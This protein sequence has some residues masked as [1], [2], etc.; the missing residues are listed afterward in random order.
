MSLAERLR[1]AYLRWSRLGAASLL[2][3][4]FAVTSL[5]GFLWLHERGMLLWFVLGC[6]G[7]ASGIW[8]GRLALAWQHR[9]RARA[10]GEAIDEDDSQDAGEGLRA[11]LAHPPI[12]PEWSARETEIYEAARAAIT[13]RLTGPVEWESLPEQAVAVVEDVAGR[14][15]GGKR[16][17]LDFTLPEALLLIDRVA[18][19]YREFLRSHVPFSDQL[20]M[21]SVHWLWSRQDQARTA[22]KYGYLAYRGL[23]LAFNPPVGVLR[24]LERAATA[25]LQDRLSDQVVRDAQAILLEEVAQAAVDLYSGRLKF[26]DA[27]LIEI[28]LGSELRDRRSLARPDDPVRIIVVGQISA[29]K[30]T[31]IN[32]LAGDE[33]A[34]TDL[35]PT[36]D[37]LTAHEMEIDD[38][39]CRLIDT[40]GLDGSSRVHKALTAEILEADMV[41]WVLRANR[42]GRAV[43]I[44]LRDAVM[45]AFAEDPARRI[46]PIIPLATAVDMLLP[47]WPYTENR[48]P[49]AAQR[50]I[51]RM[52]TALRAD[53]AGPLGDRPPIPVCARP[54]SWNL[55]TLHNAIA[56]QLGDALMTQRNRRRLESPQGLR[57]G[58]NLGRAGRGVAAGVKVFGGRLW[59]AARNPGDKDAAPT[60][61]VGPRLPAKEPAK[62][63]TPE[64]GVFRKPRAPKD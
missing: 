45:A 29:G 5:L 40:M 23:R 49:E 59:Q 63:K 34:E 37:T 31:L 60:K 21:R 54:P 30:S 26:S 32:A 20:S 52:I 51:G 2:V 48:L 18:L 46:P 55:D 47:D 14:M 12:D 6:V 7:L 61:E 64:S 33:K 42:P 43:D 41:L 3:L 36:T 62:G 35:A 38:I 10:R 57:F 53:F 27:E 50:V 15:S 58:E 17:A 22:W 19:R 13:E 24:E 39:P 56:A 4:P 28:Q 8:S 25:G 44:A 1:R 11:R 16:G 9:R